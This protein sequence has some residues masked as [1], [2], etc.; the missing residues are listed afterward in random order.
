MV[1]G[2]ACGVGVDRAIEVVI[3]VDHSCTV[4]VSVVIIVVHSYYFKNL[5]VII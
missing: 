3:K 2:V 5:N 4:E 1:C